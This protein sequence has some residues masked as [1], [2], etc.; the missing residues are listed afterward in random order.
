MAPSLLYFPDNWLLAFGSFSRIVT[1]P[2]TAT[3]VRMV[4]F[5]GSTVQT[6]FPS[7]F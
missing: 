7:A 1:L 2:L 4:A 5:I 6:V 3:Q